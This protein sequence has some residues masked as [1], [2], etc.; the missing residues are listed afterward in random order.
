MLNPRPI[1]QNPVPGAG[2]HHRFEPDRDSA[3]PTPSE[4][5]NRSDDR[6]KRS[7]WSLTEERR[8]TLISAYQEYYDR[9]KSTK[10]SQ[11]K[12]NKWEDIL[13]QFQSMCFD[14]GVEIK[15]LWA[16][17]KEKWRALLDKYKSVYDNNNRKGRE[18]KTFQHNEDIDEFIASSDKVN[19]RFVNETK[20]HKK[21]YSS[22][23][24]DDILSTWNQDCGK[25]PKKRPVTITE[26][27]SVVAEKTGKN[28]K[29]T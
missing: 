14:I 6:N 8:L 25:K 22:N 18:W 10:S 21:D 17:L 27:D 15:K 13:K 28:G 3:S 29:K 11:G 9:L 19:P 24:T 1:Y 2:D 16:K 4:F 26:G 20:A 12:K 23:D 7:S 5:L